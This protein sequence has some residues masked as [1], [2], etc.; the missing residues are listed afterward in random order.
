MQSRRQVTEVHACVAG[1]K[2]RG[3]DWMSTST[4]RNTRR[5]IDAQPVKPL[6]QGPVS[7]P[8]I[9][10]LA[11]VHRKLKS[12]APLHCG[13]RGWPPHCTTRRASDVYNIP[14]RTGQLASS[15]G[16]PHVRFRPLR[17][18]PTSHP[19]CGAPC[20]CNVCNLRNGRFLAMRS[21]DKFPCVGRRRCAPWVNPN[22]LSS[23][24]APT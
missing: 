18:F 6:L 14:R 11:S 12:N 16:P 8:R 13:R 22:P 24:G 17:L 23:V 7:T 9:P 3:C 15:R 1:G 19:G 4:A 5:Q 2:K 20:V 10:T 21:T